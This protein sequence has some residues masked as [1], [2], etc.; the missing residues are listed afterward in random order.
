MNNNTNHAMKDFVLWACCVLAIALGLPATSALAATP[1]VER[2]WPSAGNFLLVDF[3][4]AGAAFTAICGAGLL[5]R[6]FRSKPGLAR[7]LRI[8][9]GSP[10]QNDRLIRSLQA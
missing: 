10:T 4:D 3:A 1:G 5:V 9:V 8:T 6:D 7:A 2:V